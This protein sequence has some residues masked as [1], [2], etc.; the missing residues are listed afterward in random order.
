MAIAPLAPISGGPSAGVIIFRLPIFEIAAQTT[1]NY[2][3]GPDSKPQPGVPKGEVLKFTF[4]KSKIFPGTVRDYWVYVPAQYKTD[5]PACVYVQQDGIRFEA[6]IVFDNLIHKGEM[7]V[8]IGIFTG[9]TQGST[10]TTTK[11]RIR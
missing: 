7:P 3:P 6:P 8:T 4:D 2:Q 11:N 1:D 5:K 9:L 10:S